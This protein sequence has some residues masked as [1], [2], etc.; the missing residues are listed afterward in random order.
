MSEIHGI[1]I[2]EE[3]ILG[4]ALRDRRNG[5]QE[6]RGSAEISAAAGRNIF[7][8]RQISSLEKDLAV[9][10]GLLAKLPTYAARLAAA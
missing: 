2:H 7:L 9:L 8:V 4:E 1:S 6:M 5:L 3:F 10:D